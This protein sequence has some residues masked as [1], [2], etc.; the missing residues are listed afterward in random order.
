MALAPDINKYLRLIPLMKDIPKNNLWISYD[1]EADVLYM[2]FTDDRTADNSKMTDEG[3]IFRY[4]KNE[5]IG[6]TITDANDKFRGINV[7]NVCQDSV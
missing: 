5:I 6:I 3:I 1:K 2:N 4:R 7:D